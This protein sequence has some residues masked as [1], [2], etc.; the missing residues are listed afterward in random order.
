[1]LRAVVDRNGAQAMGRYMK[2]LFDL[3]H[4]LP[5]FAKNPTLSP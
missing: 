4:F 2:K 3:H 1:M 5:N